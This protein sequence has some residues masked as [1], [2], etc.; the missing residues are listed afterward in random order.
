ML[1][2]WPDEFTYRG[3]LISMFALLFSLSGLG[4]AAYVIFSIGF[5]D[6]SF[7]LID[8]THLLFVYN[9]IGLTPQPRRNRSR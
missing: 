3:F 4:M 1:W 7:V 9:F 5:L 8:N 6:E 2:K